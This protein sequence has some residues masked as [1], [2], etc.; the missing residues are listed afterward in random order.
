MAQFSFGEGRETSST[1]RTGEQATRAELE[2]Q[3][4]DLSETVSGL[5]LKEDEERK[6]RPPVVTDGMQRALVPE[7]RPFYPSPGQPERPSSSSEGKDATAGSTEIPTTRGYGG[8][9]GASTC[10]N[11]DGPREGH[12]PWKVSMFP[13]RFQY[14][15]TGPDRWDMSLANEGWLI[16]IHAKGRKRRFHPLHSSMPLSVQELDG[17]RVTKRF[18]IAE[19]RPSDV[20]QDQWVQENMTEDNTQWSGYT[21]LKLKETE[22]SD[23][24]GSYEKIDPWSL[25]P[26]ANRFWISPKGGVSL[27]MSG[28]HAHEKCTN[29]MIAVPEGFFLWEVQK[30]LCAC[31][32]ISM[33]K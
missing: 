15:P 33:L 1:A 4:R 31:F 22:G 6:N 23:D 13:A 7:C 20:T 12:E 29:S 14:V 30:G 10:G 3:L 24:D 28:W 2:R 5:K 17:C 25:E 27:G 11:W 21:F 16:R 32:T 18:L 8:E 9:G 26:A 19:G